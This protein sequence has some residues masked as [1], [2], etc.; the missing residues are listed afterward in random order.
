MW[1]KDNTPDTKLI[2]AQSFN[3]KNYADKSNILID[4]RAD[5]IQQWKDAGGIGI[6]YQSAEQVM[7]E[8]D[9]LGL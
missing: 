8:L 5:N 6:L 2:L 9:K 3:K 7:K 1:R 4:D